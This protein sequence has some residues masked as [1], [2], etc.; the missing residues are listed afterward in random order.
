MGERIEYLKSP[1]DDLPDLSMVT[2]EGKKV[3][4]EPR[5]ESDVP[6]HI[7]S[8]NEAERRLLEK[9]RQG[10]RERN[11]ADIEKAIVTDEIGIDS[12]EKKAVFQKILDDISSFILQK[13]REWRK[14]Y[15]D[16][17]ANIVSRSIKDSLKDYRALDNQEKEI[18][19]YLLNREGIVSVIGGRDLMTKIFEIFSRK[20]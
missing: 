2:R 10:I 7:R 20:P 5:V 18:F 14:K 4:N 15:A 11:K 13:S 3:V 19:H 16:K 9:Q 12:M 1:K 6:D 8:Q 17:S